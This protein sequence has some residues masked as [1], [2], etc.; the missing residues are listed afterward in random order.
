MLTS[1]VAVPAEA[2][3]DGAGPLQGVGLGNGRVPKAGLE[4]GT[5]MLSR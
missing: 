2:Q 5:L 3:A 1:Y 4:H